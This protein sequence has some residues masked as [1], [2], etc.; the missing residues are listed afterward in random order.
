MQKISHDLPLLS[1]LPMGQ[2]SILPMG[3]WTS[4]PVTNT[5]RS[6]ACSFT[7]RKKRS[8]GSRGRAKMYGISERTL[9]DAI[10]R[11]IR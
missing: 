5:Q 11:V 9:K 1:I 7:K 4:F 6:H 3:Q 10:L 8:R 2:W